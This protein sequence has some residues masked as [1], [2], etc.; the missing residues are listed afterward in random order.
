MY[1]RY[2]I[3]SSVSRL[4]F[5]RSPF[6][7][8]GHTGFTYDWP[9]ICRSAIDCIE[10]SATA[11]AIKSDFLWPGV[12]QQERSAKIWTSFSHCFLGVKRNA[13]VDLKLVWKVFS[14]FC[15][16]Y[17]SFRE[18]RL[19][20]VYILC[21]TTFTFKPCF[22]CFLCCLCLCLKQHTFLALKLAKQLVRFSPQQTAHS[23]ASS[24]VGGHWF[25]SRERM[26]Q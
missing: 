11:T 8:Y 12:K 24:G 22:L 20:V 21:T 4:P 15:A 5:C 25:R 14:L 26:R 2:Q 19:F 17:R 9:P 18:L 10:E 1:T 16:G 7:T 13:V 6:G 3:I 23:S